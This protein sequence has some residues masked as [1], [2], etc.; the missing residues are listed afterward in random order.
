MLKL[1]CKIS[2]ADFQ[3]VYSGNEFSNSS[4]RQ[5]RNAMPLNNLSTNW[6]LMVYWNRNCASLTLI[7]CSVLANYEQ[8]I[9]SGVTFSNGELWQCVLGIA[10]TSDWS[11]DAVGLFY[12]FMPYLEVPLDVDFTRCWLLRVL[13][14]SWDS[15]SFG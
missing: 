9:P 7:L 1:W 2:S 13:Y 8:R 14:I 3:R 11:A 15:R 10:D 12:W 4:K 6:T 5:K